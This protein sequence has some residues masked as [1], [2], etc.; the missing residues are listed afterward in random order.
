[1][2]C[3][4]CCLLKCTH[5]HESNVVLRLAKWILHNN[6]SEIV[7]NAMQHTPF[8]AETISCMF[9]RRRNELRISSCQWIKCS[10]AAL[11]KINLSKSNNA[12]RTWQSTCE[13]F[14]AHQTFVNESDIHMLSSREPHCNSFRT[15]DYFKSEALQRTLWDWAPCSDIWIQW[16][17]SSSSRSS[18][19][20]IRRRPWQWWK[21]QFLFFSE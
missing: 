14:F 9:Q 16:C 19:I 6:D 20:Q 7:A 8:T 11:I 5:A 18:I 4:K 3:I 1:M 12:Q 15:P 21:I 17:C 2:R 10:F 13:A